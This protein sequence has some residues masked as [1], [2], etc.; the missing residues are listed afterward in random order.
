[1]GLPGD[2]VS[3]V[4]QSL[5]DFP[6]FLRKRPNQV[7]DDE[8]VYKRK[9]FQLRDAG[10]ELLVGTDSGNP[11][12]FHPY[13]TWLDLDAWVN[14]FGIAPKEALTRATLLAARVMK[15]DRDYGSIEPGKYAD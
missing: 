4:R 7:A 13:A 15:A 5:R 10:V 1:R 8:A 6:A 9:F 3:D 14:H 2:A 12:H 11:G